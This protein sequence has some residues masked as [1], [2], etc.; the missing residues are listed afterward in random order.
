MLF[1]FDS[2]IFID[3]YIPGSVRDNKKFF[4]KSLTVEA[5][6]VLYKPGMDKDLLFRKMMDQKSHKL[7]FTIKHEGANFFE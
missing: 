6:D 3:E 2:K 1:I 5:G 4:R 7:I